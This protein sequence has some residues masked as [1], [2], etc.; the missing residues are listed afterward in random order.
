MTDF[1][2]A[3]EWPDIIFNHDMFGLPY[4]FGAWI[5]DPVDLE[6]RARFVGEDQFP[7]AW[8]FFDDM[9]LVR[10]G[11]GPSSDGSGDTSVF[12]LLYDYRLDGYMLE[13][14]RR[15]WPHEGGK[16]LPSHPL[17]LPW[18]IST[19]LRLNIIADDYFWRYVPTSLDKLDEEGFNREHVDM[20]LRLAE[21]RGAHFIEHFDFETAEEIIRGHL[22]GDSGHSR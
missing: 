6:K 18:S 14:H 9:Y 19:D 11:L 15:F 17:R 2:Q 4:L 3:S 13:M 1:P 8:L 10:M 16:R 21:E 7:R 20:I 5:S 12:S 22:D